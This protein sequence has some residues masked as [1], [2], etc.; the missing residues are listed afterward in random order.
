MNHKKPTTR[1]RMMPSTLIVG[2]LVIAITMFSWWI[3]SR[4]SLT[5]QHVA[6]ASTSVNN[7]PHNTPVH[8][9]R[10]PDNDGTTPVNDG[11][12][13]NTTTRDDGGP[14]PVKG[15]PAPL[16]GVLR[17]H[18]YVTGGPAPGIKATR[19]GRVIVTGDGF[20]RKI[21]VNSSGRY[22]LQLPPGTY[23]VTG[24]SPRTAP[25]TCTGND[26]LVVTDGAT[27]TVDVTCLVP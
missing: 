22:T 23:T 12:G 14:G 11:P 24:S 13:G 9:V 19:A 1:V 20:K 16:G 27:L 21:A 4:T 3:H 18:L 5:T 6:N 8:G 25:A 26:H 15:G 2:G 10:A 17:G 7:G